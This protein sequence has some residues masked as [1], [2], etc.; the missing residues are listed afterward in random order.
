M[1]DVLHASRVGE[2]VAIVPAVHEQNHAHALADF[3]HVHQARVVHV[4]A[5]GVGM[6]LDAKKPQL[7]GAD[8]LSLGIL[9]VLVHGRE[10]DEAGPL[11]TRT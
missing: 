9:E 8:K 1:Q 5:L 2:V 11:R 6:E 4:H 7:T 10:A 3:V